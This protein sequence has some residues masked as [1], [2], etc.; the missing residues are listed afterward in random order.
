VSPDDLQRDRSRV[1]P[2]PA[3]RLVDA[4]RDPACYD[5]E[6]D[7]VRVVETHI[8]WVLL[9]GTYAYKIKK[10][11]KLPF[12]DFSTAER[13]EHFC[14]EELRL[15]KR[16]A[17]E[18]YLDVVPIGGTPSAPH[19][20]REPAFE[21]AVKMRQF[22]DDARLDRQLAAGRVELAA[23]LTFAEDLARFHAGLPPLAPAK[24][25][26]R[27]ASEIVAAAL[28]NL[29]ELKSLL[30]DAGQL[31]S[32]AALRDWTERAGQIAAEPLAHR[33]AGG[34]HRECHGDLHLENLLLYGGRI[35]AFDALEFEP[36]LREIDVM[37]E[38]AFLVMDL[39]AH[40]HPAFAYRFLGRYLE[41]T[42]DYD[43]LAVL[44]FYL[45]ERALIRAKVRSLRAAQTATTADD[46][47]HLPYLRLAAALAQP[48]RPVL[49]ITH[50]Y[51]GSGK[52]HVTDELVG[53][54]PAVRLRSDLERKR[55]RGLAPLQ[56]TDSPVGAGLYAADITAETYDRLASSSGL[57]LENGF[58]AIV[59]AAFLDAG[60]RRRFRDIAER[61]AAEFRILD[62]RAPEA[63]L[64][65]RIAARDDAG[66]DASEATIAVLDHQLATAAALDADERACT[67]AVNTD[68]PIDFAAVS[69]ALGGR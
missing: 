65:R 24:T 42:G 48:P 46:D 31:A 50:G 12:L 15:N 8:S 39:L 47:D 27:E 30:H 54:L 34:A 28:E 18:L 13:R 5:H 56:R 62:C 23:L 2:E 69:R 43:G 36:K 44:R 53:R 9:T 33:L 55:L 61:A 41:A 59:D 7:D 52:T 68:G 66:R 19:V 40:G 51:S 4:L 29:R 10:P 14:D 22:P 38:T 20:G 63:V 6:V 58:N 17:P 21:H 1:S 64:R 16:L 3:A 67:V 35:V 49:A 26:E 57:A 45:V 60:S 32:L 11:V 25:A 37:N